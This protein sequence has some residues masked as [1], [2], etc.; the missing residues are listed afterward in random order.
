MKTKVAKRLLSSV[1]AVVML[2]CMLPLTA[3][4]E[5]GIVPT[6]KHCDTLGVTLSVPEG[7]V[8]ENTPVTP[9]KDYQIVPPK[10]T[11]FEID[12]QQYEL[13]KVRFY[14]RG[15]KVLVEFFE[16]DFSNMVVPADETGKLTTS[17]DIIYYWEKVENTDPE[18]PD[19]E[20]PIYNYIK[21]LNRTVKQHG[22]A[23]NPTKNEEDIDTYAVYTEK[24]IYLNYDATMDM[25][26][27]GSVAFGQASWDILNM[28][29][30][31]IYDETTV[32]LHFQF[33]PNV[34]DVNK[35]TDD[36]FQNAD[37]QSDM[38][39]LKGYK[40]NK[41]ANELI[42]ICNW[43]GKKAAEAKAENGG[44]LDPIIRLTG[45][46]LPIEES[47]LAGEN[48]SVKVENHGYVDGF[49]KADDP[50]TDKEDPKIGQIDGGEK[51]DTFILVKNDEKISK[52][53]MIKNILL[54]DGSQVDS[55]T[56]AVG[57]TVTFQ[58]NSTVPQD[59]N[60]VYESKDEDKDGFADGTAKG[61]YLL[62]F[63]D[64]MAD[65]FE[66]LNDENFKVMIG[67]KVLDAD[68]YSMIEPT[69]GC[70]FEIQLNLVELYNA[71]IIEDSYLGLAP[72]IVTYEA[73]LKD[74]TPAGKYVNTA[75][76]TFNE[77]ES[78]HDTAEV[79]TFGI[80]VY[81]FDQADATKETPLKGA[82]FELKNLDTGKSVTG[83]SGAD[84]FVI[85][86]G[87]DE[88]NYVLRETQ[89]PNDY[90]CSNTPIDVVVEKGGENVEEYYVTVEFAN[91]KIPH[92]GGMGTTIFSIVGGV[93]IAM[94]G[95][96]FVISRR[97]RR[98]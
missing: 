30:E 87:L 64:D 4:A 50:M 62:T 37:L 82:V 66:L 39:T 38:F 57:D 59:L 89:A 31:E 26:E 86:N 2:V 24:N 15:S 74:E 21:T 33:D 70:D 28:H 25:E 71:G 65:A 52:P 48:A 96:V 14:N 44:K 76:V 77:E 3:F 93:L 81:K 78:S 1:L 90:V 19:P 7:I 85:F 5:G 67:D 63:H 17:V 20:A 16:G 61:E 45:V 49:V 58:L 88:G 84:G 41:E 46:L 72:I 55:D 40:I 60:I 94:A 11:S 98:A 56:V 92:T 79:E 36:S 29:S 80:K 69:D 23:L 73:K 18:D 42:L 91:S 83:T 35:F 10:S 68:D 75:W 97:K 53:G 6:V 54:P 22:W 27:L 8:D 34:I 32:N 9:G 12:G 95:T 13:Q 47:C 43:D 51:D